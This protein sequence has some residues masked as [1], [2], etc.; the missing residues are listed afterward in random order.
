MTGL[1]FS[2][3]FALLGMGVVFAVLVL[4]TLGIKA[5]SLLLG[6]A[7]GGKAAETR[8]PA[9]REAAPLEQVAAA[10]LSLYLSREGEGGGELALYREIDGGERAGWQRAARFSLK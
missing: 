7:A 4:F 6:P 5:L 8:T 2:I 1:E 10:A 9:A 3:T